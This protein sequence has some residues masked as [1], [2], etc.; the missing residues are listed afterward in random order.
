LKKVQRL[1]SKGI[2]EGAKLIAGGLGDPEGTTKGLL[3]ESRPYS[4]MFKMT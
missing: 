2:E 3:R 1:I 4:R